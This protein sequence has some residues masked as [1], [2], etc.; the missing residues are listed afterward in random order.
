MRRHTFLF[1]PSRWSAQGRYFG[2]EDTIRATGEMAV[3]HEADG[4]RKEGLMRLHW[5]DQL[6]EYTDIY[7]VRPFN[8]GDWTTW[9]VETPGLGLMRGKFVLAADTI[10]SLGET[11]GG[12]FTQSECLVMLAEDRYLIRGVLFKGRA[13]MSSWAMEM[14][15]AA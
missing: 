11:L 6:L 2:L 5:P 3:S 13:K 8:G 9:E 1:E 4:W 12:A 7:R 10:L 15:R 14:V